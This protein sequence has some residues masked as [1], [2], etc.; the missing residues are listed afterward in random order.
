MISAEPTKQEKTLKRVLTISRLN[1]WSVVV[2]AVLGTLITLA[3]GDFSGV[4]VGFLIGAAGWMEIRGHN[5]LKRRKPEGMKL[6]VRSQMFLLA[7]ILVYCASRLGSFD[8]GTVMGNLTPDMEALLKESGI[9]K[10]DVLPLVR[11]AFFA[12]YGGFALATLIYQGG[13]ALYYRSRIP[14]VTEA[15]TAPARP[16]VSHL[17]PSA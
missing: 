8:N 11:T 4:I 10:A 9:D 7:V 6:L 2:F 1:G 3:I 13:M 12:G 16:L 17:P 14:V 15:L 5:L